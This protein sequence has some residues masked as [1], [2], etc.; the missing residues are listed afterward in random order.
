[1]VG[2]LL[3][4]VPGL[5]VEDAEASLELKGNVCSCCISNQL[6][7][8][9]EGEVR[10]RVSVTL[11]GGP[12]LSGGG[13]WEAP[14]WGSVMISGDALLGVRGKLSGEIAGQVRRLCGGGIEVCF[15]GSAGLEVFAG[16]DFNG[17][18]S[19]EFLDEGVSYSG[20]IHGQ[21]GLEGSL[22]VSVAGCLGQD[23]RFEFCG[24]LYSRLNA[25]GQLEATVA[26]QQVIRGFSASRDVPLWDTGCS[27]EGSQARAK[28]QAAQAGVPVVEPLDVS[29]VLKSDGEVLALLG[30]AT[31]SDGICARV[32]L[33]ID[34]DL[35]QAR[36]AFQATLELI[37]NDPSPITEVSIVLNPRD[38]AGGPATD[39]FGSRPPA[40]S[41]L[42]GVEGQGSV[43]GM[44]RASASWTLIPT[45]DAAPALPTTYS[46][47]GQ[48]RY[49]QAG[50]L[51]SVPLSPVTITVLPSP[52]LT[53]QYFHQRDVFSDD[54]FTPAI[55]PSVPFSLAVMVQNK[56]AGAA[57]NMRITS[58]QPQIIENEKGLLVDFNILA[59]EVAGQNLTPSLTATFGTINPGTNAIARWLMTST[60]QGL[61]IDYQ[62][63]FEHID[64]L[65]NPRLSL[66]DDV[67]IH[68]MIHL[69]QAGGAFEDG[70]P[71]FLVNDAPDLNDFPDRLYLSDGSTNPVQV[72]TTAT[73]GGM[74]SAGNLSVS[75]TAPMPIGW[76]YLRAP[77]PANGAWRLLRVV[78]SDGMVIA[79]N[80]NV[81]T[82]DRTFI[83]LGRRPIR[84]NIL[85]L[86]DYDSTGSYTLIYTNLPD[87]DVI[88]PTSR[89]EPLPPNSYSNIPLRWSG[90][91]NPGGSGLYN[92]DIY[93][94]EN[95]GGFNRWRWETFDTSGT[96]QGTPG[97]TYAFYSIAMDRAGNWEAPP[98]IPDAITTVTLTN[99][100][101]VLNV[102]TNRVINEGETLLLAVTAS[103]ADGDA[104]IYSL[105]PG[106]PPGAVLNPYNGV[107]TWATGEGNAPSTNVFTAEVLDSGAPRLGAART[108]TVVV[109]EVNA[110]PELAPTASRK[111]NEGQLL[112]FT[113]VG[114]DS[115]LPPQTLVYS[116][117]PN[118]PAGAT[119]NA[120]SGLFQWRPSEIQ[121]GTTN[122][123]SIIVT[124]NGSPPLS[125]TQ[126][127]T[128]IV[129]DTT[130]DF[131]VSLGTTNLLTGQS[132]HLPV[133][134]RS[135]LELTNVSLRLPPVSMSLSNLA[136]QNLATEVGNTLLVTDETNGTRVSFTAATGQSLQGDLLLGRLAFDAVAQEHSSI[137]HLPI[138]ALGGTLANGTVLTDGRGTGGRVFVIGREPLLDALLSSNQL[139]SLVLYGR[140]NTTYLVE[141]SE[142]LA[143]GTGWQTR[144]QVPL[145]GTFENLSLAATAAPGIFYRAREVDGS[146]PRRIS[147]FAAKLVESMPVT[148]D[149]YG[150]QLSLSGDTL[151]VGAPFA[152]GNQSGTGS[153][154]V[155]VRQGTNWVLQQKLAPIGLSSGDQFGFAVALN[156][157][158]LVVGAP[159]DG[160]QGP[161]TGTAYVFDRQGTNWT[162]RQRLDA[163]DA[164]AG[165]QFGFSLA[166]DGERIVVGAL[167][168]DE[169]FANCGA[170]Y[171]FVRTTNSNWVEEQ[172][173][174]APLRAADDVFGFHVAI[175][176][177]RLVV[178]APLRDSGAAD[179]GSAYA[180]ARNGSNWMLQAVL[181]DP[182][183]GSGDHFGESVAIRG[184]TMMVSERDNSTGV[185]QGAVHVFELSGTNWVWKQ[186]LVSGEV[187]P[188]DVF[189]RWISLAH[190]V[191]GITA[192]GSGTNSGATYLF[193]RAGTNW[194]E[195]QRLTAPDG[196]IGDQFGSSVSLDE[197]FVAVGA[198]FGNAG[199]VE[200][201]AAYVFA[202]PR[203]EVSRTASELT[204]S[205][206]RELGSFFLET[207]PSLSSGAIWTR[208]QRP[209]LVVGADFRV[210]LPVGGATQFFRIVKGD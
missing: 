18:A 184:N 135:G 93:V 54:P 196:A 197:G 183:S 73:P 149:Q 181:N 34:Q 17:S 64:G 174:T 26:G 107:L 30:V 10:A 5:R 186:K 36:D 140:P 209:A 125:A 83:G 145:A 192:H 20:E 106:A 89:V 16:G 204:I 29:Q 119:L 19:A 40:L 11:A 154:Y 51:V 146:L 6:G 187:Q 78:R 4:K 92:F 122:R 86:L 134:L 52:R 185:N 207:A 102:I 121:G 156:G 72:V 81:W 35:I 88:P 7:L 133:R 118:T 155:H 48:L 95:S 68:E 157:D 55:E 144:W 165:D 103:D 23:P 25:S 33:R 198:R 24:S 139:R 1:M 164:A 57:R 120:V 191:V 22:S 111:I 61:F 41:G 178:G 208:V 45:V 13:E 124:D 152:A 56:G 206:R 37:N 128:V 101:P 60:I 188:G 162:F 44:A 14:G 109:I 98:V 136:L 105:R 80:T 126:F 153:A 175:D 87:V 77:D 160:S 70:R 66:I 194:V 62:A 31:R 132:S 100:A 147:V 96:F 202:L 161:I 47:G 12:G 123:L 28:V 104:L 131:V 176:G 151:L 75:L 138:S 114:T 85:H 115:D 69:V 58:A 99:R 170:A 9:G 195:Q 3:S 127:F 21:A 141:E 143:Q 32:R 53:V 150:R 137:V 113:A 177:E 193:S 49:R 84:E 148:G 43:A 171:V 116:L 203:V 210:S 129:R 108:F 46:I 168:R 39:F 15:S 8:E 205:W 199:N 173:L 2:K 82:T 42:S 65:G 27:S 110:R 79:L 182:Q 169:E 130:P 142:S 71:D 190:G 74:P 94:S 172:K 167:N 200:S 117:G 158:T 50:Q 166:M 189:G 112:S 76:A 59:T 201:G 180:Y 97:K 63:T 159:F 179:A 67:S 90:E 38:S 163:H 91:D